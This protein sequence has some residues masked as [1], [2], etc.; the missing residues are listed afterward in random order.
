MENRSSQICTTFTTTIRRRHRL[1]PEETD[2]L[3]DKFQQNPKPT[4][5]KIQEIA[6]DTDISERTIQIWFQNRRAK[7]RRLQKASMSRTPSRNT[8]CANRNTSLN[9]CINNYPRAAFGFP[10]WIRLWNKKHPSRSNLDKRICSEKPAIHA[11]NE[12]ESNDTACF[13]GTI[14]V[15]QTYLNTTPIV[16][17]QDAD[18][19]HP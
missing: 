19:N 8:L 3:T 4:R 12:E 14:N 2:Y 11:E 10:E 6:S 5:Q 7:L 18:A 9:G 15:L 17:N 1:K 13:L 16:P